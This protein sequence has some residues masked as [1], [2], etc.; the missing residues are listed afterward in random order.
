MKY[1]MIRNYFFIVLA[2]QE[3]SLSRRRVSFDVPEL[4]AKQ[5]AIPLPPTRLLLTPHSKS[6][7]NLSWEHSPSH[8][9][10]QPCTYIV[11]IRDPRTYSWSTYVSS[12]PGY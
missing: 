7:L 11:E 10:T 2:H 3:S 4:P 6:S 12:L 9:R 5:G 1:E 8:S